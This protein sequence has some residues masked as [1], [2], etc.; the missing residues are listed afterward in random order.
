MVCIFFSSEAPILV[1]PS[2]ANYILEGN[3]IQ[4]VCNLRF[5][6][7]S[8]EITWYDNYNHEIL[9]DSQKY[10]IYKE[11]GTS[12]LTIRETEWGKDSGLYRCMASNAVGNTS[13]FIRLNVNSTYVFLFT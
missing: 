5:A 12:N 1:S 2:I 6:T 3:S 7:P 4:L 11:Y 9:F 10:G 8:S 13:L